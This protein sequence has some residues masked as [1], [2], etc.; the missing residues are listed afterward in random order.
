MFELGLWEDPTHK[1]TSH[2]IILHCA[3]FHLQLPKQI[4]PL[5]VP[6]TGR[7]KTKPGGSKSLEVRKEADSPANFPR[8][9]QVRSNT[10]A[11]DGFQLEIMSQQL[12]WSI[13]S[14]KPD[15]IKLTTS[16]WTNASGPAYNADPVKKKK[17]TQVPW[18]LCSF[19]SS[20]TWH[21]QTVPGLWC[22]HDITSSLSTS[23]NKECV[24]LMYWNANKFPGK[25]SAEAEIRVTADLRTE[26]KEETVII[27]PWRNTNISCRIVQ[28]VLRFLHIVP[29]T[30]FNTQIQS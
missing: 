14:S 8:L 19:L 30:F 18:L 11:R 23:D 16:I 26:E 9:Y 7:H 22:F 15:T 12:S 28:L 3:Q 25:P 21:F 24:K 1:S 29:F 2:L 13:C 27:Q 4:V 6:D 17:K 10:R 5:Q 20:E